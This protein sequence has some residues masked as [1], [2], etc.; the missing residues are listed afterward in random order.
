MKKKI[1]QDFCRSYIH[2]RYPIHEIQDKHNKHCKKSL[3]I[4]SFYFSQP[5]YIKIIPFNG[6]N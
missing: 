6:K 5:G 4:F 3:K 2:V 1:R